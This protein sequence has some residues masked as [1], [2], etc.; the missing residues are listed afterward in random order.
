MVVSG[1]TTATRPVRADRE[2]T[3]TAKNRGDSEDAENSQS[4]IF[5]HLG[6]A[7]ESE[8]ELPFLQ[9]GG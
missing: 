5:R 6:D 4:R 2:A 3:A 1:V 7:V 8:G 9:C